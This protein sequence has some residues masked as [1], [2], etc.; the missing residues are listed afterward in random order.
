MVLE[1]LG[2]EG[3]RTGGGGVVEGE[4]VGGA[5]GMRRRREG[6]IGWGVGGGG[7]MVT[8][9]AVVAAVAVVVVAVV[10]AVVGAVV[11]RLGL[12]SRGDPNSTHCAI[13]A[14]KRGGGGEVV[15]VLRHEVEVVEEVEVAEVEVAE[16]EWVMEGVVVGVTAVGAEAWWTRWGEEM[17]MAE[18]EEGRGGVVKAA[19]VVGVAGMWWG[20]RG[21]VVAAVAKALVEAAAVVVAAADLEAVVGAVVSRPRLQSLR[22]Q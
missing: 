4:V 8:A 1:E 7:E 20:W 9:V 22:S 3:L 5:V 15:G 17:V 12:R 6:R 11:S 18:V 19:V 21:V 2:M 16:V 13:C 10:E 14:A